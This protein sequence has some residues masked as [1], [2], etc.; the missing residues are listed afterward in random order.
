MWR[1]WT[2]VRVSLCALRPS[3]RERSDSRLL[4]LR[5]LTLLATFGVTTAFS[6]LARAPILA[7]PRASAI[8]ASVVDQL[9]TQLAGLFPWEVDYDSGPYAMAADQRANSIVPFLDDTTV[10]VILVVIFP[11]IITYLFVKDRD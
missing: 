6:A 10:L 2:Y 3:R 9:S 8:S 11:T 4:M 5:L 1:R 7:H